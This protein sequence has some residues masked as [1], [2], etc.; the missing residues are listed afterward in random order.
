MTYYAVGWNIAGYMPLNPA[1]IYDTFE[2]ARDALIGDLESEA[3]M[4]VFDG[5]DVEAAECLALADAVAT[6]TEPV[7]VL[8]AGDR[9]FWL[10]QVDA[11]T[12]A[13]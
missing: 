2:E 10:H 8:V 6:W 3:L 1:S 13:Y 9:E 4:L 7:A 5:R 12:G 11:P